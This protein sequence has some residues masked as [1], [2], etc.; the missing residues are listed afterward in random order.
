[1]LSLFN[2]NFIFPHS[3]LLNS[4]SEFLQAI[5]YPYPKSRMNR[6]RKLFR[7][8]KELS[9]IRLES[10]KAR[11][12]LKM[13]K[14]RGKESEKIGENFT[15]IDYAKLKSEAEI[16]A[17]KKDAVSI[18]LDKAIKSLHRSNKEVKR[19]EIARIKV[20]KEYKENHEVFVVKEAEA[21][22]LQE[23]K[24][25]LESQ[26][27]LLKMENEKLVKQS[28][29]HCHQSLLHHFD[30]LKE[31]LEENKKIISKLEICNREI[32][33]KIMQK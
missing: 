29:L 9:N 18:N 11:H 28:G 14:L 15:L 32:M 17:I 4:T 2:L 8:Q 16:L 25:Q 1:M 13:S 22:K 20:V 6:M 31:K 23:I 12:E 33:N 24:N 7:M 21:E 27:N 3:E 19:N 10:I 30:N 26:M 5:E